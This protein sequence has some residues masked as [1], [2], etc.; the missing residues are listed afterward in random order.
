MVAFFFPLCLLALLQDPSFP[1]SSPPW[2]DA[3]LT[4]GSMLSLSLPFVSLVWCTND[5]G[6]FFILFFLFYFVTS[7]I[8]LFVYLLFVCGSIIFSTFY[9][10][11]IYINEPSDVLFFLKSTFIYFN[12]FLIS[13]WSKVYMLIY[14]CA[15][16]SSLCLYNNTGNI[17]Y[18]FII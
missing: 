13:F 18:E 3:S 17:L 4:R 9:L 2:Q 6:M 1:L 12:S 10:S 15:L 14:E 11:C 16:S 8:I 5:H 7:N